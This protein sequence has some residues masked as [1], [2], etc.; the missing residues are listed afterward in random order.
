M[1]KKARPMLSER[2]GAAGGSI[3]QSFCP[4]VAACLP[5]LLAVSCAA[6]QGESEVAEIDWWDAAW[7]RRRRLWIREVSGNAVQHYPVGVPVDAAM[8]RENGADLR[9]VVGGKEVATQAERADDGGFRVWFE[10][11]LG[12]GESL[13]D[14]FLYYGNP[15]ATAGASVDWGA[16]ELSERRIVLEGEALRAVYDTWLVVPKQEQW[17]TT[18]R[19]LVDLRSGLDHCNVDLSA[20]GR[21]DA[22]AGR[23]ALNT[24]PELVADG[25][26][27]RTVRLQWNED[28]P[29]EQLITVY[30]RAPF[31]RIDYRRTAVNMVDIFSTPG[32]RADGWRYW[33]R[34]AEE[35]LRGYEVYEKSY[36]NRFP[37]DGYNDPPDAGSL[38]YNGH[39]VMAV[40]N[41]ENRA[42]WGRVAPVESVS[43][44][45]LLK[46]GFELFTWLGGGREPHTEFIYV[47]QGGPER[48]EST[49]EPLAMP[50]SVRV[51]PEQKP[52]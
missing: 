48:A 32:G 52:F 27:Y 40:Y 9:V 49:G 20:P 30:R 15:D 19:S 8:F 50:P 41:E 26:I 14:A 29:K 24:P 1:A 31:L 51:G 39:F 46:G 25:P 17:E 4:M 35:W 28:R 21:I 42:G 3:R 34:G 5:L 38:S 16:V 37:K 23:F 6:F 2:R 10:V 7:S 22:A 12:A 44:V 33:F 18:I 36:Y 47:F 45:K 13:D 11:S 43:I